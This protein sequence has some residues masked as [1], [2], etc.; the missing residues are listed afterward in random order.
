VLSCSPPPPPTRAQ[1][2]Q[3]RD[4]ARLPTTQHG[5]ADYQSLNRYFA[6]YI[7]RIVITQE[8]HSK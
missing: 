8:H 3:V 5:P 1:H 6:I 2:T 4:T 7:V